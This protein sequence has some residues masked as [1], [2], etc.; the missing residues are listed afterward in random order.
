MSDYAVIT[1]ADT[2][3]IQRM[4]PGPIER[5]WSFLTDSQKRGQWLA[6]GEMDLRV[7]GKVHLHFHH[8][9]LSPHKEQIPERYKAME[10]GHDSTGRIA[11]CDP[12]NR[13]VFTWDEADA[14]PSEVTFDLRT[15]GD[16][17]LL[18]VTHRR[19]ADRAAMLSV[20][21]GWHTHLDILGDNLNGDVPRPFWSTHSKLEA[22][23][24]RLLA[25]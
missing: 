7:G 10:N 17:V 3:E 21:G 15:R 9:S 8:A 25:P 13:L 14:E 6:S 19:L 18:T 4:L 16:E 1:A 5:V 12:P 20:A 24:A 23:Y 22:E 2:V 11:E